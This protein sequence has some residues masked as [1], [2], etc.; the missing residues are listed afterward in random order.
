MLLAFILVGLRFWAE[1]RVQP[2]SGLG[3]LAVDTRQQPVIEVNGQLLFH[4]RAGLPTDSLALAD[5]GIA[6][7]APFDFFA[8]GDLLALHRE[9]PSAAP[10][11]LQSL[12]GV[13]TS[14]GA[15][16]L[17]C[18]IA[19]RQCEEFLGALGPATF[20][21]ERRTDTVY[22]ADARADRL[23]KYSGSG[24]LLA[25]RAMELTAPLY[26][27][28]EEG[29]LY[30]TQA[31]SDAVTVLKPD[32]QDFGKQ[33]DRINLAVEDASQSGH[34]FPGDIAWLNQ[35]WWTIMQS[36]DGSTAGVYRFSPRWKFEG[37]VDLPAGALPVLLTRWSAKMLVT[38]RA[39]ESIYRFDGA[40]RPEK[41]FSSP[42]LETALDER[43]SSTSLSRSLQVA[44]L[45]ILFSA[46]VVLMG[47]GLVQTLRR[48]VYSHPAD[49]G[50]PGFDINDANIEWLDP[51]PNTGK[52]LRTLGYALAGGAV[53]AL[54]VVFLARFDIWAI[55]GT[56]FIL[57]GIGAFY[58]ALH[59][60]ADCHL[61]MLGD[62]LIVV[63]HTNTYRVGSGPH[64]QYLDNY[65]MIDDVIVYLGNRLVK[66]FALGPL[67]QRFK[68]VV[69]RGIKV[70]HAT[71]QVKMLQCRHPMLF[72]FYGLVL[73]AV[74]LALLLLTA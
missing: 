14:T 15:S 45:L 67:Q 31:G 16:L 36:R 7:N 53:L 41:P 74:S 59:K 49:A 68:P 26:L 64:I 62:K 33:L 70:D 23:G 34:I 9:P 56:S 11:P 61:G 18:R 54:L 50:E 29:I 2:E 3:W 43:Q 20:V 1:S 58:L 44:V 40:A 48:K 10:A 19:D 71:L 8:N 65:V 57:S 55:I 72:G 42:S 28:F 60:S 51:D 25:E 38:D 46:A 66:H 73:A 32:D 27:K 39:A 12:L 63:D 52:H 47:L 6:A 35:S 37:A 5:F 4:D 21:V 30:L 13:E 22:L 17:R 24:E 69:R